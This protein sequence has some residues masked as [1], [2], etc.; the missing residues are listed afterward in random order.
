MRT[1]LTTDTSISAHMKDLRSQVLWSV[2]VDEREG[3]ANDLAV[4][5]DAY[6]D[7]WSSGSD[8]GD[9]DV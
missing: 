6:Q 1:A 2:N 5:G 8:D 9:D 4:I 3:L 7:D